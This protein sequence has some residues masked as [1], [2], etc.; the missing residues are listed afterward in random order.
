MFKVI[1]TEAVISKGYDGANALRF[2]E[3]SD[4]VRF[5]IGKRVYD[6]REES[7]YRWIN[8]N[9]KAFNSVCERI[10]KMQLKDGSF[11]NLIGR[12]DEE[13]WTDNNGN[14]KSASVIIID[15][16]E[17]SGGGTKTNSEKSGTAEKEKPKDETPKQEQPKQED[18][19]QQSTPGSFEGYAT[20]G[21][22]NPFFP[23]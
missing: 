4:G 3:N 5:R 11:I 13:Q 10:K 23:D 16:I 15:E 17:Y 2:T 6:S 7:N 21:G 12:Y 9:V 19:Q 20:F 8:I 14:K 22:G 18:A 1:V